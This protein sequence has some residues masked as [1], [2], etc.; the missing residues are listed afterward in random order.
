MAITRLQPKEHIL[1]LLGRPD[2]VQAIVQEIKT[3]T[4]AQGGS[5]LAYTA[6]MFPGL[7]LLSG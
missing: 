7:L 2:Y 5:I 6:Q 4:D 1:L 3:W